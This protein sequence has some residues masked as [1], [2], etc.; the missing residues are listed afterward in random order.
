MPNLKY[1]PLSILVP[2][3]L[4]AALNLQHRIQR[5][6]ETQDQHQ[7]SFVLL[8]VLHVVVVCDIAASWFSKSN[9]HLIYFKTNIFQRLT[10]MNGLTCFCQPETKYHHE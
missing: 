2:T 4:H 7:G 10:V 6:D 9:I 8:D 5:Y 3:F 1:N